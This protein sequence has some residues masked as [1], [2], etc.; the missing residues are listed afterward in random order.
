MKA[1][2]IFAIIVFLWQTN[3]ERCIGSS[4]PT[5][6][7]DCISRDLDEGYY[8]CCYAVTEIENQS[9]KEIHCAELNKEQYDDINK[10][11]KDS[12]EEYKQRTGKT[13][14]DASVDC[15]SNY[16]VISLMSLIL[17]LF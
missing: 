4:Q 5:K 17:L 14:K 6:R 10:Y 2:Y 8:K 16:V 11:I 1:L 13:V 9:E 3:C 7:D 15:N 12:K